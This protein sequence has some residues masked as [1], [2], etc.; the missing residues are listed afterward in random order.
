VKQRRWP[1]RSSRTG[2]I[3][4]NPEA[5]KAVEDGAPV[6]MVPM[7][8]HEVKTAMPRNLLEVTFGQ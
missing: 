4:N 7:T 2:A 5:D 1:I 3:A 6:P 8:P